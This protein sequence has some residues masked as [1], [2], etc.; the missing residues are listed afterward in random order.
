MPTPRIFSDQSLSA[1]TATVL[2]G[3]QAGHIGR[4]LR[5]AEGD[6]IILFD[7][8][9]Y[10]H[11]A[12]ITAVRSGEITLQVGAGHDPGLESPIHITLLQGLCRTQRMDTI[13]QK[14]TELGA[15]R[16]QPVGTER[17][18]AKLE[19]RRAARRTAHWRRVAIS[20]CEQCGRASIPEVGITEPLAAVLQ[21]LEPG[22]VRIMLTP[23]GN[24]DIR[25]VVENSVPV[26]L[27]VGPEGGLTN[28]E[29]RQAE[30]AGFRCVRIGPRILRT[31]T[32]PVAAISIIQYLCGDLGI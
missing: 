1:G 30:H 2:T 6:R 27:F 10:D 11:D 16:I 29:K 13:I 4:V 15:A 25:D 19:G 9:G 14:A 12:I 32:A 17:G 24:N 18:V 22:G 21:A 20:A 5:L 31:E 28:K 23:D 26:V 7:G 3:A 8:S